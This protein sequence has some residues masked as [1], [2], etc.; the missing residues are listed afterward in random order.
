MAGDRRIARTDTALPD[1]YASD[2][3]YR[4]I[5]IVWFA[6]ALILQV[7]AQPVLFFG[8]HFGLGLGSLLTFAFAMLASGLI[9]HMTWERGMAQASTAWRIAT[10]LMLVFLLSVTAL[11]LGLL[12]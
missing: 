8:L 4:P 2:T 6:G 12:G 9:W 10:G 1:W 3:A 5:P 11:G 7:I